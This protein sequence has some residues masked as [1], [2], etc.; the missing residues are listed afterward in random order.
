MITATPPGFRPFYVIL[1][2]TLR[3]NYSGRRFGIWVVIH[4]STEFSLFHTYGTDVTVRLRKPYLTNDG[5]YHIC[6]SRNTGYDTL[7]GLLVR[8]AG[9]A[10][11]IGSQG[12]KI[13]ISTGEKDN[14][15]RAFSALAS[16]GAKSSDIYLTLA[17]EQLKD[18]SS[19]VRQ[20][21]DGLMF[22]RFMGNIKN[23]GYKQ[24]IKIRERMDDSQ[25]LKLIEAYPEFELTFDGNTVVNPHAIIA[26]SRVCELNLLLLYSRY[27][28]S[29]KTPGTYDVPLCDVG[30]NQLTH[31]NAGRNNVHCCSPILGPRDDA[32][33]SAQ[34]LDIA[35][36]TNLTEEQVKYMRTL[37]NPDTRK[38]LICRRKAQEC[39]KTAE[40]CISRILLT[41]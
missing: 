36:R 12:K 19:K 27:Q 6:H 22:E 32:R 29:N 38:F 20:L 35:N 41:T 31:F 34:T 33:M 7:L 28:T 21:A 16:V 2:A 10:R 1:V 40:K 15:L 24:K 18:K 39:D 13:T 14:S 17:V 30:G 25:M 8:H 4:P 37:V 11:S 9:E 3:S 23:S 5:R 26:A